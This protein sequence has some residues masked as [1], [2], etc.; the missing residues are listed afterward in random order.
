VVNGEVASIADVDI[1]YVR[2]KV[3][4]LLAR[5]LPDPGNV[6]LPAD[7]RL[8]A[9]NIR[10]TPPNSSA[11]VDDDSSKERATIDEDEDDL[12]SQ[13]PP[14]SRFLYRKQM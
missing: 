8:P 11:T 13:T 7:L 9:S 6:P 4:D 2:H 1:L 3:Q 14:Q 5:R 12:Y 10:Y